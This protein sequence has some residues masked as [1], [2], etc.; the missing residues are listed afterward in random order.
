[1]IR[2][3]VVQYLTFVPRNGKDH[4]CVDVDSQNAESIKIIALEKIILLCTEAG[5]TTENIKT[6]VKVI[7]K[8]PEFS[9]ISFIFKNVCPPTHFRNK[10]K[11]K[12]EIDWYWFVDQKQKTIFKIIHEATLSPM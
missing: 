12:K 4:F 11:H 7:K 8:N 6:K 10:V 2:K 3:N 5:F 9:T 1:M